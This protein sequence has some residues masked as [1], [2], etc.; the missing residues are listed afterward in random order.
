MIEGNLND[1]N[2]VGLVRDGVD[3]IVHLAGQP[4]VRLSWGSDF[5][6]YTRDNIDATQRLLEAA[7]DAPSLVRF[8][9][10]SSSSIYGQAETFPTTERTLPQPFSPYGVTKLAGE[11]LGSL[12]KSNHGVPVSSFR[13]F[14]VYGPRQRPD[15][16]F[17][18]FLRAALAHRTLTIYG[19]GTQI[20]DYTYVGDIA[21]ALILALDYDGELPAVMNLAGGSSVSVNE[22]LASIESV[23]GRT[24][25]IEYLSSVKGDVFRTGGDTTVAQTILGWEPITSL[26]EGIRLQYE[27]IR[28]VP[29]IA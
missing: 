11:H 24:L 10:A 7:R 21:R 22:V 16:A 23:T 8:L 5:T 14:T 28:T 17:T 12:Y 13:F 26:D 9:N 25:A 15:M 20:R 2:L 1:M 3:A 19:D 6:A 18:R 27:W 4:G 29:H